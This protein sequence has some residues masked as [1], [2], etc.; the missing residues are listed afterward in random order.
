V[1][2]KRE[3]ADEFIFSAF[4]AVVLLP[5]VRRRT[6]IAP[7]GAE[8]LRLKRQSSNLLVCALLHACR[9][10]SFGKSCHHGFGPGS[11][12]CS[13][14]QA[15]PC[16]TR[17]GM[18]LTDLPI[19]GHELTTLTLQR[20]CS[21]AIQASSYSSRS[22]NNTSQDSRV[23]LLVRIANIAVGRAHQTKAAGDPP[24]PNTHP[25]R[26][27]GCMPPTAFGRD[28]AGRTRAAA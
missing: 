2:P 25:F 15:S 12:A 21:P 1:R 24:R 10:S 7:R 3:A 8:D 13:A 26:R 20:P 22:S 16:D 14:Q 9:D 19:P 4:S 27:A 18:R 6:G 11:P 17:H 5:A 23:S 28:P